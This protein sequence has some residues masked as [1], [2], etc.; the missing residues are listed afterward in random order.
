MTILIIS[1]TPSQILFASD[2]YR[3]YLKDGIVEDVLTH[4]LEVNHTNFEKH[5]ETFQTDCPKIH[6]VTRNI[7]LICGGDSRFSDIIEGLNKH[8]NIEKQITERLQQ[9]GTLKAFWSCHIGR[10]AKGKVELTSIIY[11]CGKISATEHKEGVVFDSFAPEMQKLF[12]FMPFYMS[13]MEQKVKIVNEF[14]EQISKLY[15]GMAG[16]TPI[17]ARIDRNGFHWITRHYQNF[18][19]YSLNWMPEKIETTSAT[20]FSWSQID[21]TNILELSIECE[22]KMLLFI[23]GFARLEVSKATEGVTYGY[24]QL[25]IDDSEISATNMTFG[26]Y[27]VY[28]WYGDYGV[29]SVAALDKGIHTLRMR[30]RSY[31]TEITVK[32]RDRRLTV[33]KSFYQGGAT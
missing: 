3:Y 12:P 20:E 10:T 28:Q 4:K 1:Y 19:A 17:I 7:G 23:Q 31:S 16:G 25:T 26:A 6:R 14:F 2:S 30:F 29:H 32:A 13:N 15:N 18:T 9:K 24:I 8:K 11:E 5:I 27:P 21:W 22:S 33:L